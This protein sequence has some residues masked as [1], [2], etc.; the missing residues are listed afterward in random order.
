VVADTFAVALA[1]VR[2]FMVVFT[3][4]VTLAVWFAV[5]RGG[6]F[7]PEV[8]STVTVAATDVVVGTVECGVM[9]C[10]YTLH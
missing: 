6:G 1:V 2:G 4:T 10:R 3:V 9:L 7:A 5:V 8:V